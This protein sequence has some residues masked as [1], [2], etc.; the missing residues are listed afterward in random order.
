MKYLRGRRVIMLQIVKG[1]VIMKTFGIDVSKWQG[2][3]DFKKAMNEGVKFAIL[4]AGV[5]GTLSKGKDVKFE[6]YYKTCKSLGL[7]IGAYYYSKFTTV[8]KAKEEA[9]YFL[10]LLDGKQFEYPVYLDIED[11]VQKKINKRVLTD[12]VIAFCEILE[13]AGYYV[14]IYSSKSFFSDY[15]YDNE[16]QAY[17]HWIA[18]W[19]KECTYSKEYGM[20]QFGGET[21]YIRTNKIAGVVCD[22]DYAF[23]DYP[24]IIKKKGLNGFSS[25]PKVS[26]FKKYTGKSSSLVDALKSIGES[27]SFTYRTKIAKKNGISLYIGS[28][29][30][31][32][33]LLEKLKAGK[34]IK[35]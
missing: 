25:M 18:Q 12:G 2:N 3:F 28:A 16:L 19:S 17:D 11:K 31:N 5:T 15:L 6:S 7:P 9:Y 14:G 24:S 20:W 34:L 23:K 21:N 29:K 1:D 27:F 32:I 4:R 8:A 35:P 22:Q 33:T 30:Q 10:K 13:N 26:Y